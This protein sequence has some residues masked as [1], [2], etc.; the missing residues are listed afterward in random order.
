MLQILGEMQAIQH[1]ALWPMYFI[2]NTYMRTQ[3]GSTTAVQEA[4]DEICSRLG[5]PV[6]LD[7][8]LR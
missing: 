4:Y 7:A 2:E 6:L 5:S 8:L 3:D 1:S